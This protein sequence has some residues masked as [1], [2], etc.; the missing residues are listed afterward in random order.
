MQIARKA[1]NELH[2]DMSDEQ[3]SNLIEAA[4]REMH[5]A[6]GQNGDSGK[7]NV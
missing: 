4:V 5:L 7:E 1:L 2:I 6:E 3:L